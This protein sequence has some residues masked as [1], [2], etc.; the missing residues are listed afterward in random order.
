LGETAA[1]CPWGGVARALVAEADA[2]RSK[3]VVGLFRELLPDLDRALQSDSHRASWKTLWG[4]SINFDELAKDVIVH[5]AIVEALGERFGNRAPMI[6]TH[7]NAEKISGSPAAAALGKPVTTDPAGHPLVHAGMEHTYGYLF[8][9]LRT[10]FGYKR[11][12]W[13]QGE[14]EAGFGLKAGLL[15]PR[16]ET[17]TLFSNV[18]YFAGHIAFRGNESRLSI[19]QKGG[20]DLPSEIRDFDFSKLS[21]IRL[22]ETV[23]AKDGAGE[24]RTVVLRTDFVPFFHPQADSHLLV[25]SVL[26]P[27]NGGETLVTAFPVAQ[28]FVDMATAADGLGEGKPVQ[29]RYNGFVEGVTGAILTGTRKMVATAPL[30]TPTVGSSGASQ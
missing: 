17:G 20:R 25:Y 10:S 23:S 15:G 1:D 13:V 8:S 26:D 9:L 27:S 7:F 19:L 11:A 28:S 14:I 12:R 16:P 5:P 21:P 30:R 6:L 24:M 3:Q 29:T 22:E 2:G 18:T 4:R